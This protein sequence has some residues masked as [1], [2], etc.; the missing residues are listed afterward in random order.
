MKIARF[1]S[2]VLVL[3]LIFS[4]ATTAAAGD[5]K[6]SPFKEVVLKMMGMSKKTVVKEVNAVGRGVKKSAD[7]VVEEVKDVGKLATGDASKAK[8]VLV[9]PVKGATEAVGQTAH[10]VINAP[11]E[12]HKE[13]YSGEV[14]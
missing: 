11:I 8:D 5:K 1:A 4:V 14:K 2:I 9:K 3:A 10:D 6:G 7:V 13:T 12:A